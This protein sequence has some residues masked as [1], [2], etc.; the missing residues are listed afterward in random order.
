MK[1]IL[2][3]GI[4][5]A[6]ASTL[7]IAGILL[8]FASAKVSADDTVFRPYKTIEYQFRCGQKPPGKTENSP[9][10]G[11]YLYSSEMWFQGAE[12]FRP[13]IAKI[14]IALAV[15][16]YYDFHLES[17][18]AEFDE[19][20]EEN[21]RV[22]RI[23]KLFKEMDF[24]LDTYNVL[25][26]TLDDCDTV[27]Y[28][29]GHNVINHN[30]EDYIV[31]LVPIK[32]TSGDFEWFSN[33]RVG[34]GFDH[35]GFHRAAEKVL[36]AVNQQ[37]EKTGADFDTDHRVFLFTGHSRGAAVSNICAGKLSETEELGKREW[38]YSYNFA[39]PGVS[40]FADEKLANIY[41][42]NN[43]SDFVPLVPVPAWGY[44]RYGQTITLSQNDAVY[45][46]FLQQFQQKMGRKYT[47]ISGDYHS[48]EE[49]F[50]T[51][52]YELKSILTTNELVMSLV[53]I[54]IHCK[55]IRDEFRIS[56]Y[57]VEKITQ[58]CHRV[59]VEDNQISNGLD[60]L[61]ELITKHFYGY[62]NAELQ[63]E[64]NETKNVLNQLIVIQKELESEPDPE[65]REQIIEKYSV[66]MNKA[67]TI[68]Q[69]FEQTLHI[70]DLKLYAEYGPFHELFH[71]L[72]DICSGLDEHLDAV[73]IAESFRETFLG[74]ED[75]HMMLT[76]DIWLN[77]LLY[78]HD[79]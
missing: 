51:L 14:S 77:T 46:Q 2:L 3:K 12:E 9:F 38:I 16:A 40:K 73:D 6:M 60:Y 45:S 21:R 36:A 13:D 72:E 26:P 35:V 57:A 47:G 59:Y 43:P 31:Y 58:Y 18:N 19:N 37:V 67:K 10:Y 66:E 52:P 64:V 5:L 25:T 8:G 74:K 20:G 11:S 22:D 65:K 69:S 4:C 29:I 50:S 27:G 1:G 71:D 54:V 63:A 48:P 55:I 32:G 56:D 75:A 61:Q 49:V 62:S 24:S 39:C 76:Y 70:Y 78:G 53:M 44:K 34:T 42:I 15:S 17:T 79:G 23:R 30:G 41:N 7:L 68:C 33:L 28:Y